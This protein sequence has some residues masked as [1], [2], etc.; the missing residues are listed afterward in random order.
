MKL[1]TNDAGN[2]Q[3]TV[4]DTLEEAREAAMAIQVT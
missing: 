2:I 3:F 1:G 4:T